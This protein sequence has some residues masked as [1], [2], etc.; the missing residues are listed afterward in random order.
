MQAGAV[1]AQ[2]T[3]KSNMCAEFVRVDPANAEVQRLVPR[4]SDQVVKIYPRQDDRHFA[5][6]I[7]DVILR[8]VEALAV[9]LFEKLPGMVV[10]CVSIVV[11]IITFIL[12]TLSSSQLMMRQVCARQVLSLQT[13]TCNCICNI[14]NLFCL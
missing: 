6:A 12:L 8:H 10:T 7:A 11:T 9:T 13:V 5:K 2:W 4:A 14:N 1:R 3:L